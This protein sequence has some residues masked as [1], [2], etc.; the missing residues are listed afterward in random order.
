M[1]KA[2]ILF[3]TLLLGFAKVKAQINW[4]TDFEAARKIA[5]KT[6][7]KV[8]IECFHPECTHCIELNKNLET[9]EL[10][11]YLNN[12]YTNM[13][14]N[15]TD[16]EQV[17][18]LEGRN[19]RLTN[20]PI[21][22]FFDNDGNFQYFIEP[23]ETPQDIIRQFEEERG[24]SCID[25]EKS[26]EL[27]TIEKVRCATFQ[28]LTKSYN[29]SNTICT[30]FFNELPEEEKTKIGP[31]NVFKKVVYST[32]N[33]FFKYYINHQAL[34]ASLEQNSGREK[35]VF[36]TVIQQQIKYLENKGEYPNWE[37][38]SIKTYLQKMGA[39]EKQ[40]LVWTWSLELS[41]YSTKKDFAAAKALCKKMSEYYPDVTTFGFLSEKINEKS[42]GSEMFD[43]FT[44]IKDK[45]LSGLKEPKQKLQFY[46]QSAWY[47]GR[48]KQKSQ[49]ANALDSAS[50]FGMSLTEK[51]S[52]LVKYCQ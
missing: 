20:Y 27:N 34:A 35:D 12:N 4:E 37:I 45:W 51:N 8:L 49:C 7:K 29:K 30:K 31:W 10:S 13:K 26:L 41:N 9:P 21:F 2:V 23:R 11:A 15:L 19:I 16:L 25:C 18:L 52:L 47:Y 40:K 50:Q 1:K 44:E 28:R 22:L 33:D 36:I 39:N 46:T 43:Y 5:F 3:F 17:K 14:L 6:G 48:N 24:N 38:D 42:S 32:N